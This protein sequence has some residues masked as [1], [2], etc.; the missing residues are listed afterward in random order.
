MWDSVDSLSNQGIDLMRETNVSIEVGSF[1]TV[2]GVISMPD[3]FT[4][5]TGTGV[6]LAHGAGNDMHNSL[7]VAVASGL[8]NAGFPALRF[9]FLFKEQGRKAPDGREV[10]DAAWKSAFAF[11]KS[12]SDI[13]PERMVAAG[14][15]MGG[16]L[17][18]ELASAGELPADLLV[19]LGYPLHAL[20]KKDQLRDAHLYDISIPMLFFAG[21]RDALCDLELLREVLSKLKAP[22]DLEVI[23][24]GDHSFDLPKAAGISET[25]VFARILS[26]MVDWLS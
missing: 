22:W 12:H 21:S 4:P 23:D 10:L 20:G 18:A 3:Q 2:S 17:A 13:R 9:N 19:F 15:S 26:R 25:E 14:K 6:V 8:A 16:R 7:L 1:G 24:G 5:G 11:M